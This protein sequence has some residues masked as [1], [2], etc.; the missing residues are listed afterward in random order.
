[1]ATLLA[2]VNTGNVYGKFQGYR[3]NNFLYFRK[4]CLAEVAIDEA[5]DFSWKLN[6]LALIFVVCTAC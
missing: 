2:K 1:L 5:T 3:L 6:G 4:S